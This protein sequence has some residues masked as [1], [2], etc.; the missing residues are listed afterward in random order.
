MTVCVLPAEE[1]RKETVRNLLEKYL[2]EFSQYTGEAPDENGL[3]GYRYLDSYWT[4][5]DRHP[6]LLY[7]DGKLAGFALVNTHCATERKI[8]FSMAE[9]FV[10]SA[11]RQKNVG[12]TAAVELFSRHRGRWQIKCHPKNRTSL[13][14]W[15]KAVTAWAGENYE[16]LSA[17]PQA[18]YP[19]GTEASFFFFEK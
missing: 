4:D 8:D 3:F 18:R 10:L 16:F 15:R 14:F 9:F 19:D 5:K 17:Q 7:A 13:I 11:Y 2:Y 12:L 1:G 6:Y